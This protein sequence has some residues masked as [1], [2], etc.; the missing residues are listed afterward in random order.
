MQ[1]FA[2]NPA[3][4]SVPQTLGLEPSSSSS[5]RLLSSAQVILIFRFDPCS[6]SLRISDPSLWQILSSHR[7]FGLLVRPRYG[8]RG[9]SRSQGQNTCLIFL[10]VI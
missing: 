5:S 7:A 10:I 3:A 9:L 8:F 1:L 4:M 6:S 2:L